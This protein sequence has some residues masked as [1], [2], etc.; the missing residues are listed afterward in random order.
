MAKTANYNRRNELIRCLR[1]DIVNGQ[2][3][4][5][6]VFLAPAIVRS[7]PLLRATGCRVDDP[8]L[9]A[10]LSEEGEEIKDNALDKA[11]EVGETVSHAKGDESELPTPPIDES[12]AIVHADDCTEHQELTQNLPIEEN[13]LVNNADLSAHAH[14]SDPACTETPA[15]AEI[16]NRLEDD[17]KPKRRGR[18]PGSKNKPLNI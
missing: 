8:N 6:V 18:K 10:K 1:T 16:V 9:E 5:K 2:P 11:E 14:A 7:A 3:V 15:A 13:I 17:G 12:H 4:D